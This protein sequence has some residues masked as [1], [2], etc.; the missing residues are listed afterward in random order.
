ME[1]E[2]L[3][4]KSLNLERARSAAMMNDMETLGKEIANNQE[5]LNSFQSGSRMEQQAIAKSLG[6][7][8]D[9]V[10]DMIYQQKLS[11]GFGILKTI[12]L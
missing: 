2:L 5:I 8:T 11:A 12:F 10:A 7:S 6:M 1:A 3:T 4:G 9:Q